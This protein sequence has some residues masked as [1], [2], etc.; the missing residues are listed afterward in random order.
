[1]SRN[2]EAIFENEKE[3]S[4][5]IMKVICAGIGKTGTKSIAKA[6]R[7]L[8]FTVFDWEEQIFDFMDHWVD[9]F[10][11]G[12]EPDIKRVYHNADAVVD[13]PGNFFWEEILDA[14]PECKVIL[15]EREEE[16]WVKSLTNQ[17]ERVEAVK[18]LSLAMLSPTMRKMYCIGDANVLALVGTLNKKSTCVFRKRYRIHNHRVKSIVPPD[19]L[20]VYNVKQGWKPLCDFLGCEIPTVAFPHE[21]LKGEET[22]K[23]VSLSMT[24]FGQQVKWEI[25]RAVI[26]IISVVAVILATFLTF[27]YY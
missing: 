19:K 16:S 10:Q 6:L 15:S 1:M 25:Q 5:T 3:N 27:G 14:F 20:L 26:T 24:R 9:V 11:N 21:N 22:E 4:D 13:I 23:L 7:H 8:G 17:L 18:S 12:A 2:T